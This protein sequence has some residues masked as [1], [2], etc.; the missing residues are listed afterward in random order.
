MSLL[1]FDSLERLSL[2][3]KVSKDTNTTVCW[4]VVP[5]HLNYLCV[6]DLPDGNRLGSAVLLAVK[7]AFVTADHAGPSHKCY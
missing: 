6:L 5:K 1:K 2:F 7:A 3:S 4:P